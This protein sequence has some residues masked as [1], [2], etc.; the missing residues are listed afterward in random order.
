MTVLA[1]LLAC[2]FTVK[3]GRKRRRRFLRP[4][5]PRKRGKIAD[6]WGSRCWSPL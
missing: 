4:N 6:L 2:L 5:L 1:R 3:N